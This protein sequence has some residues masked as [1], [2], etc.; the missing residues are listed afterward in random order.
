[1][2]LYNCNMVGQIRMFAFS[3]ESDVQ[4][5]TSKP[6]L[7]Y[8]LKVVHRDKKSDYSVRKWRDTYGMHFK[9]VTTLKSRVSLTFWELLSKTK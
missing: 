7:A 8:S 2:Y 3:Q 9:S 1:M 4:I 5:T 6:A